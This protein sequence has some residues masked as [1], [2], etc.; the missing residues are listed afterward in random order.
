MIADRVVLLPG[1]RVGARAVMG[2]GALGK[3]NGVYEEGS[4]WIGNG[5][6]PHDIIFNSDSWNFTDRGEAICLNKGSPGSGGGE[7]ITPFGRA[8]YKR[9]APY[10]VLPYFFILILNFLIAACS[11]AYWSIS[12]V[13]AAQL[14]R[15]F[16]IHLSSRQLFREAWYRFGILYGLIAASFIIV[17]NIQVLITILWVILTKWAIIGQ[18]RPGKYSWDENSYCQR[19]QLHLTFSRPL[20]KGHG[21]GGVLQPLCG[22]AYLVWYFRALGAT[23]GK[24]CCLYPGGKLGLMTE[25][26]LV[27][28]GRD[29]NLDDCSVVAHINSR[30]NFALN[31][32]K[33][34]NGWVLFSNPLAHVL[35]VRSRCAMRSG[36]RLLSGASMEDNSMLCEHTLLTSGEVAEAGGRYV[37]WP[38]KRVDQK[39]SNKYAMTPGTSVTNTLVC[40]RCNMLPKQAAVTSCG[41][42]F[43]QECINEASSRGEVCP[44]CSKRMSS[45]SLTNK[46][47]PFQW[48]L[49]FFFLLWQS[50]NHHHGFACILLLHS[51]NFGYYC[52]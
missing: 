39:T 23:T 18:R 13:L 40:P 1:T 3:R 45:R 46:R 32:L 26:D 9:E 28:I 19:W 14:L 30:G 25:P 44:V 48:F 15:Q 42:I 47:Y 51:T 33:I 8:F 41:H 6:Y 43:C 52:Y 20:F 29:V 24:N 21:I 38:G 17:L 37:G 2:S 11:A 34:G 12:A 50:F 5:E 31:P 10:F 7:T 35:T 4:T 22:T 49:V 27:E 36:S 16:H